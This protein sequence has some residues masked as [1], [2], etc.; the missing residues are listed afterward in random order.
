MAY[1]GFG[2]GAYPEGYALYTLL[3]LH[4]ILKKVIFKNARQ[5]RLSGKT[6]H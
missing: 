1:N 3:L 2:Y 5:E 6:L 4:K